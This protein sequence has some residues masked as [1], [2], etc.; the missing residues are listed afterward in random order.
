M[1]SG[2]M[3]LLIQSSVTSSRGLKATEMIINHLE[4]IDKPEA[5]K[6]KPE[7]DEE[8]FG[9]LTLFDMSK[10]EDEDTTTLME[11]EEED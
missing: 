6:V 3:N 11:D 1:A 2:Y 4:K 10:D 8:S 5:P 9:D 7:N